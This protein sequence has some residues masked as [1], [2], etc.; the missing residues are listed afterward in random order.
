MARRRLLLL[1][2]LVALLLADRPAWASPF[3]PLEWQQVVDRHSVTAHVGQ[4]KHTTWIRDRNRNF[5]DD[6]IE[7]RF[8]RGEIVDVIV[9]LNTCLSREQIRGVLAPFGRI[10]YVGKLITFVALEAVR[11][12]ALPKLAALPEVAMIEWQTPDQIMNDVSTRAIQARAS[13]TYSPNTAQNQNITGTGV[14]IAILDTGVDNNHQAFTGKFVAGFNAANFQDTNSNNVDDSCE[15]APL[16][17][18]VCTDPDDEPGTGTLDPADNQGHGSHVAGIALGAAV[19]NTTCSAPNDGS[20][21]NTCAGVAPAAGL[22]D[23][24]VCTGTGCPLVDQMEGIDWVATRAQQFNIRAANMSLGGCTNDDGTSARAQQVNYAVSLG[25]SM[26]ISHGNAT[27]CNVMPGTQLLGSPGSASFAITVAA[28]NDQNTVTRTDDTNYTNFMR[29]PRTDF[30]AATPN[31]LALKPDIAAPGENIFSAQRQTA[32][33]YF[34]QS[35]TSMASPHVAGAVALLRQARPNIDPGSVKLL[36]KQSAD[37]TQNVAQFPAVDAV[38]DNDLGAG[39]LNVGAALALATTLDL[40]FPSCVGPPSTPGQPCALTA[41]MPPWNNTADLAT[42]TAPKVG[43]QTTITAQVRNDGAI[44]AT[45]LIN[46]GV[47]IFAA[48][49]NQFFHI[50][51]QQVAIAANSTLAVNQ[52]W[53]PAATNHQC[54]QVSIDFANDTNYSN[55]VTQRNLQVAPSVFEIRVENPLMVP[56]EMRIEARSTRK[57]WACRIDQD[58]FTLDPFYDCPRVVRVTFDAPRGARVGERA[59]CDV[60]VYATPKGGERRLAGGVT[61][62]TLVPRP[63]RV[64]GLLVDGRGM[65]IGGAQVRLARETGGV[66]RDTRILTDEDGIFIVPITPMAAHVVTVA[67]RGQ[68]TGKLS[69]RPTCGTLTLQLDER[70]L[71]EKAR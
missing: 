44:Q 27:N 24:R 33:T 25:V 10:T 5:I 34:S 56:A 55:N 42:T 48:G 32:S 66:A 38:W 57:D 41:P 31:L 70:G 69:L 14:N 52:N 6:E 23:V 17:N 40:R 68:Q 71:T 60:A 12:D 47:Y 22:V 8:V 39:M 2:T 18:G 3:T 67:A 62:Q 54:I 53:T 46:F 19:A 61:V 36:L 29:G 43:Q 21:P 15:A 11:V 30:N 16:G 13:V 9:D 26:V 58:T 50:G 49:N 1:L 63:C 45:A 4:R 65:P 37:A 35:G 7:A 28:T 51:T 59:D 64:V 20:T